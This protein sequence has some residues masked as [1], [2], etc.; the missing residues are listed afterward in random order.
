M[1]IPAR[2]AMRVDLFKALGDGDWHTHQEMVDYLAQAFE[3]A[4]EERQQ[5]YNNRQYIFSNRVAG[6]RADLVRLCLIQY[7]RARDDEYFR[8]SEYGRKVRDAQP[9]ELNK[10]VVREIIGED[11]LCL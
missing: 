7:D 3:V 11:Y 5:Q 1:T 10:N 4:D 6:A 2:K 9:Q 8:L